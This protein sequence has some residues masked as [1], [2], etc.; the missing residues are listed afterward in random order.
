MRRVTQPVE[1][2]ESGRVAAFAARRL[3]TSPQQLRLRKW[4]LRG[5][6]ESASVTR[7]LVEDTR[8]AS[9]RHSS[10]VVKRLDRVQQREG[11][12]YQRV[13]SSIPDLAPDLLWVEN[14]SDSTSY[15]YLE[16]IRPARPWPWTNTAA[17][18]LVLTRLAELHTRTT[19]ACMAHPELVWDYESELAVS[20]AMTLEVFDQAVTGS[21]SGRL[22]SGRGALRRT[23]E[24]MPAMRRSLL[25]AAPFG[26]TVIHGDVHSGNAVVT[27]A[28]GRER[29]VLFDWARS[30]TGSPLEDVASWLQSLGHWEPEAKRRHDTLV[31]HYLRA[32]GETGD[33]PR[34]LRAAYWFAAASNVLAGALRYH[35]AISA[36]TAASVGARAA[37]MRA[38]R[39]HLRVVRRADLVWRS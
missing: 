26:R 13:F 38:A 31:R 10:F 14:P 36:D 18:A 34:S 5:G 2:I 8:G 23:C 25:A 37:A 39:D 35:L 29:V 21:D 20:A 24:A 30:R 19:V 9:A 4:R 33:I 6:L 11:A 15:L 27:G 3:G 16:Y 17:A 32:R 1:D 12:V 28:P 7:W 22:R